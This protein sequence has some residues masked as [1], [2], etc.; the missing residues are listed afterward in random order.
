MHALQLQNVKRDTVKKVDI[1]E[2]NKNKNKKMIDGENTHKQISDKTEPNMCPP[3]NQTVK[4]NEN[5]NNI[6]PDVQPIAFDN[7][8]NMGTEI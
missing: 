4:M 8:N 5:H 1:Q 6:A 7:T 2:L 3:N